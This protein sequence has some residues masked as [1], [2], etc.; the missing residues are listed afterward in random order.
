MYL[1]SFRWLYRC[2]NRAL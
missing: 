2:L 1:C